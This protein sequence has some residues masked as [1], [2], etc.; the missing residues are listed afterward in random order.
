MD[1]SLTF[2]VE[3]DLHSNDIKS[4]NI[5]IPRLLNILN[6]HNVKATF[7]V[8]AKLLEE[9]P[10]LFKDLRKKGH[11]IALHG[12]DHERFD[13]L[14]LKEKEVRIK[15]SVEIYKKLFKHGPAG[16]RAPQMSIERETL[17]ILKKNNFLYDSSYTPFDFLQ[18]LFFPK[19]FKI[20]FES[21]LKPRKIFKLENNF[22][23][24]P[25][26]SLFIP[27]TSMTLRILGPVLLRIYLALLKLTNQNLTFFAH[28]WDF[29]ET[30]QSRIDR[31]FGHERFILN[32]KRMI[33]ILYKKGKY[34]TI[35]KLVQEK[36]SITLKSLKKL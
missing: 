35:E 6:K 18:L 17:K 16:F 23:E 15:K 12:Y 3:R 36:L 10:R 33:E 28:S 34:I 4:L 24:V 29:I 14:S 31:H 26:S 9:F 32:F 13:D 19:K 20:W 22:Y 25:L 2:D 27:L 1:I 30:P 8:P 7:F 5:G 11:E 21:F